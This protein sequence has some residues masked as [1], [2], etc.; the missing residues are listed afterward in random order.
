MYC[1][2]SLFLSLTSEQEIQEIIL[3]LK[4]DSAPGYEKI[5]VKDILNLKDVLSTSLTELV[6]QVL[7]CGVFPPE[8]K[9]NKI[10]PIYKAGARDSMNNYRPISV[11]SVF[12]KIIEKIIKMRMLSF[13]NK[14][15]LYN[16]FQYGFLKNSSTLSA[17]VDFINFVSRALDDNNIVVAVFVDFGKAFDVVSF[18]VLFKKLE[19]MGFRGIILSLIKTFLEN[20]QQYVTINNVNS[21]KLSSTCGMPQGSVLG[22]LLY[23]IY[24]YNLHR[25]NLSAQYFSFADDTVL[26]YTGTSER[27]LNSDINADLKSYLNWLYSNKLKINIDKTKYIVFKQKNKDV[28]NMDLKIKDTLLQQVSEI[29][30]LG[31]IVDEQLGWYEHINHIKEKIV[32]MIPVLFKCRNYLTKKT[33]NNVLYIFPVQS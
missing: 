5:T 28:F 23:S 20:R 9:V 4:K 1:E 19:K 6:N 29:K 18:D 30:Y 26:V 17:T 25:A 16:E 12:S 3:E 22:P 21:G 32:P 8:L 33:K 31:L 27:T 15:V 14:Y 10:T 2:N 11:T 7:L 13:I 24:V